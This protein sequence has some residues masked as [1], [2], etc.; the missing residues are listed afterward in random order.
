MNKSRGYYFGRYKILTD[1]Y[2]GPDF[3]RRCF[4]F[5]GQ[6]AAFPGM[7]KNEYSNFKTIERKFLLANSL[8][9]KFN[10]FKISDYVLAPDKLKKEDISIA[11][12]LALFT[13]EL[14]FFDILISSKIIPKVITGHSF[15][16]YAALVASGIMT[17]EEMFNIV[18]YRDIFCPPANS[19]G[20]M[21]AINADVKKIEQILAKN[22]YYISNINS[23]QQTVISVPKNSVAGIAQ[24]LESEKIK[25]KI[26]YNIP[27]PYHSPYLKDTKNKIE[28]LLLSKKFSFRKPETPLFSSV[29]NKLINKNNF[30][31]EDVVK[32]LINQIITPVNFIKQ[33]RSI[34]NLG[35]FNFLEIGPKKLFSTFVENIMADTGKE[36][37]TGVALDFLQKEEGIAPRFIDPKNNKLFSLVE[38]TIAEITGYKIKKISPEDNFQEDLNIDSIKKADIL[39]TI[40]NKLNVSTDDNFNTSKFTKI[41]DIIFYIEKT[42]MAEQSEKKAV[43]THDKTKERTNFKRYVFTPVENPLNNDYR[44]NKSKE[45]IFLLNTTDI[46]KNRNSSLKKL[47]CFL[48]KKKL[49]GERLNVIIR[50]NDSKFNFDKI[51]FLFKFF[52]EILNKAKERS[53]NL[54]LFSSDSSRNHGASP[55]FYC[56]SSFFKSLKK[57]LP[58]IFFKHIHFNKAPNE[59][60]IVDITLKELCDPLTV[61]VSYKNNKRFTFAAGPA[62]K[63]KK[64]DLNEKSVVLAIGGAKGITFS[65]IKN[66]S[67]KY[68]P[69]IYLVGR[70]SKENEL[71]SANI[72]KLKRNNPKIYYEPIDAC[73]IKSIE[74]LFINIKKRHKKIN[75]VINGAGAVKI[76][77]LEN[78]T[79]KE[80]NYEFNNR[81]LAASNILNLS[82]KY[83]PKRVINF[84]SVI[85]RYGS[86]G[87]SIY[88]SANELVSGLTAE[89]NSVLKNFSS[90]AVTVHWPPWDKT[91]MTGNKGVLQKLNEYGVSLLSPK[92]ADEL[93][94]SDLSF[95]GDK[96][97]YYLDESDDLSYNFTL[98]NFAR[99]KS[100]TGKISDPFNISTSKLIFEKFFELSKDNY[101][102]DHKIK[103]V[104]YVPAAV[105]IG[106]FLCAGSMY[107]KKFPVLKNIT[108]RNPIIVKEKPVKC[109][110]E[111]EVK[112][113]P[114][115]FSIKSNVLHFYCEAEVNGKKGP[116]RHNL[117][118]AKKEIAK[119]FIY[120][121]Y[122]SKNGLYLGPIFQNIDKAFI[123]K[124]GNPYFAINNSKLLP[125]LGL[126]NYDRLTQWTDVLFQAIGATTLKNDF[127]AI[128]I[129]I[130]KLSFFPETKI[131]DYVY[132]MPSKIKLTNN[133]IGG[134]AKLINEKGEVILQLT[135]IFLKKIN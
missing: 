76:G 122:R 38:N 24:I 66:I 126:R 1:K 116:P 53:F 97:V 3:S 102:K 49:G 78:K 118:K 46:F 70:S 86:A 39:L 51:L 68:K 16:E 30:K 63:E 5:P 9:K 67:Q 4:I 57:E 29:L 54:I 40:L 96:P 31:K 104:C 132:A 20:F 133:G 85:S 124:N 131:S 11:A 71:V 115:I 15:G 95:S 74:K 14:A 52:R 106:M 105:G 94:L 10:L 112:K 22:D 111:A 110:L 129:K 80:I 56:L 34:N 117:I 87:Q 43:I 93:F 69:I 50:A 88:T 81:V 123:N 37:K 12:N 35:Y 121:N 127:K 23:P 21:V 32:I 73:D 134:N 48:K 17:F 108:I 101:L 89:Y 45:K 99:Y 60:N 42:A 58:E 98:N 92:K 47:I 28:Q 90:S 128:P 107:F 91:G 36:I 125:V 114:R 79:D 8:A 62:N 13:A 135:G 100:L 83:K 120:P 61:D 19:L 25:Y 84:S 2:S 65:L 41:K 113:R 109:F 75:L 33:I 103:D 130:S 26:L 82:L 27:Q 6:G 18:Y 7:I 64:V 59:K 55:Y 119:S 44:G 72:A 77:F